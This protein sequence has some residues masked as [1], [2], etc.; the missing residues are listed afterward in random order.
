MALFLFSVLAP[1]AV[2]WE[3]K[4]RAAGS[5]LAAD[6]GIAFKNGVPDIKPDS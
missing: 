5:A 2:T 4:A 6:Y 3:S 1:V